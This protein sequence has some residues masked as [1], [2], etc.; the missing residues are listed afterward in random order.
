MTV[1]TIGVKLTDRLLHTPPGAAS[2]DAPATGTLRIAASE[3][4]QAPVAY[5]ARMDFLEDARKLRQEIYA[6]HGKVFKDRWLQKYFQSFDWYKPNPRYSDAV[7]SAVERQ[8]VASIAAY[9]KKATSV[10]DAIEG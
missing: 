9:E 6:R 4:P 5:L 2:F 7:L 1:G 3:T 8:N 10:M